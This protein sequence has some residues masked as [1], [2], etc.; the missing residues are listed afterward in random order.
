MFRDKTTFVIGAG[1]SAEFGM[2]VG[3]ELAK[4]IQASARMEDILTA[5]PTVGDEFF[6]RTFRR[7]W[8]NAVDQALPSLAVRNIH[9]GIHTAVSIDAFIDR[10]SKSEEMSLTGKMLIALEIAKAERES[11]LL[12]FY[13][14]RMRENPAS[15]QRNN[16]GTPLKNPDD[17][18][19]GQFFRILCDGVSNP[20][21]LGQNINIICFNYDRCVEHYLMTQISAAYR[22]PVNVARDIVERLPITHVYGDLGKLPTIGGNSGEDYLPFAPDLDDTVQL[23]KIAERIHTYTEQLHERDTL[24]RIHDAMVNA[25][26]LVFLG[27]GFNNQNLNLLRVSQRQDTA[28]INKRTFFS[29]G[30][31]ITSAVESTLKRRISHLFW[32]NQNQLDLHRNRIQI[33]FGKTCSELFTIHAMNLSKFNRFYFGFSEDEPNVLRIRHRHDTDDGEEV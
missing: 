26:V 25:N 12:P 11:S 15:L 28:L 14:D 9:E 24:S 10:F 21:E 7:L 4:R 2:P 13:W 29:S 17:T 32:N 18:W 8:A 27:F 6:F 16:Y 3:A 30:H 19:I 22:V 33:E 1:A 20:D 31:G 23:E 5:Y